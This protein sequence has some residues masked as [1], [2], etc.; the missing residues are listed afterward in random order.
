MYEGT[1]AD[2][3]IVEDV[4]DSVAVRGFLE[5]EWEGEKGFRFGGVEDGSLSK[6]FEVSSFVRVCCKLGTLAKDVVTMVF[7]K[8]GV[9]VGKSEAKDN[10]RDGEEARTKDVW[11]ETVVGEVF[12]AFD[13]DA[14]E[15]GKAGSSGVSRGGLD[16]GSRNGTKIFAGFA[17]FAIFVGMRAFAALSWETISGVLL[18]LRH[19]GFVVPPC[20]RSGQPF[21]ERATHRISLEK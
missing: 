19:L 6:E 15:S 7:V 18:Y 2:G 9:G 14:W 16:G 5:G 20:R 3:V 13:S 12:E 1:S 10:N 11:L 21:C 8:L 4:V 17:S